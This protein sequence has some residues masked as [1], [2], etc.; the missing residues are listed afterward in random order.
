MHDL[1]YDFAFDESQIAVSLWAECE[2]I[3]QS[4]NIDFNIT[5]WYDVFHKLDIQYSKANLTIHD[6]I[7]LSLIIQ[8][9]T[10]IYNTYKTLTDDFHNGKVTD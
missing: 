3:A 6:L 8:T 2:F 9:I 1:T 4:I 5:H 7:E 10:C